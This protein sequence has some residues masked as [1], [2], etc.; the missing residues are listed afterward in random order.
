MT[1]DPIKWSPIQWHEVY[2]SIGQHMTQWHG[3]NGPMAL[4][5]IQLHFCL[6]SPS[7]KHFNFWL[8]ENVSR[9]V[10]RKLTNSKGRSKLTN[11]PGKQQLELSTRT[12]SGRAHWD[13][14]KFVSRR[15]QARW[16]ENWSE[17]SSVKRHLSWLFRGESSYDGRRIA[18][19][20]FFFRVLSHFLRDM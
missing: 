2:N 18:R 6:N 14:E 11:F 9:A 10:G 13:C 4:N 19:A 5:S 3:V 16:L 1:N 20:C 15:R 12:R 8:K 17:N 7:I